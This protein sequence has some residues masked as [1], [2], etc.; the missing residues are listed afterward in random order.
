M[1]MSM[2]E[3]RPP[4]A[5]MLACALVALG[6]LFDYLHLE[7]GWLRGVVSKFTTALEDTVPRTVQPATQHL[8]ILG[9]LR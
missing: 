7:V 2:S 1:S 8:R 5:W 6:G 4:L 9:V 3:I